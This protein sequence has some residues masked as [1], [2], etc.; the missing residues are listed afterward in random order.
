MINIKCILGGH[1]WVRVPYASITRNG[2]RWCKCARC[3]KVVLR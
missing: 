1:I 3:G 2:K